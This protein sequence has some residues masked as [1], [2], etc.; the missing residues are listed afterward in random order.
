MRAG[1][2]SCCCRRFEGGRRLGWDYWPRT[3]HAKADQEFWT[4]HGR[5]TKARTQRSGGDLGRRWMASDLVDQFD[6]DCEIA[7]FIRATF[8]RN[9]DD[10]IITVKERAA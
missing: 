6:A 3:T 8:V 5:Q 7:P 2:G 1:L 4:L 10:C 9:A